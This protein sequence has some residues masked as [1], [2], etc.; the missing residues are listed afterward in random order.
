MVKIIPLIKNNFVFLKISPFKM[1]LRKNKIY[2][3]L[4][5]FLFGI[6]LYEKNN[7]KKVNVLNF[8]QLRM[9]VE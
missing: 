2:V 8:M 3:L 5:T 6:F 9:H 4:G 1:I 7:F